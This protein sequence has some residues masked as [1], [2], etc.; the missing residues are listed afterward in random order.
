MSRVTFK[1][2][3]DMILVLGAEAVAWGEDL[4][5][6]DQINARMRAFETIADRLEREGEV[7]RDYAESIVANLLSKIEGRN[8]RTMPIAVLVNLLSDPVF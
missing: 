8:K 7:S 6:P 2:R 3:E 4:E 1:K 5:S